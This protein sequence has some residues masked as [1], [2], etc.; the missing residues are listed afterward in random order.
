MDESKRRHRKRRLRIDLAH[1]VFYAS[2][3]LERM[4]VCPDTVDLHALIDVSLTYRENR[5]RIIFRRVWA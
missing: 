1:Q 5:E 2:R 4:G 3:E